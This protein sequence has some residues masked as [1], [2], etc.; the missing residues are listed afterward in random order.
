MARMTLQKT[1]S[2]WLCKKLDLQARLEKYNKPAIGKRKQLIMQ[3]QADLV[4]QQ[5]LVY[6]IQKKLTALEGVTIVRYGYFGIEK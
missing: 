3:L 2:G 4:E 1:H 5:G 6:R